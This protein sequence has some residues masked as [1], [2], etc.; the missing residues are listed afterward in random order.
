MVVAIDEAIAVIVSGGAVRAHSPQP[1]LNLERYSLDE[2]RRLR[3]MYSS[4]A[5]AEGQ[6]GNRTLV[7][8]VRQ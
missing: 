4:Q 1:G 7:R 5:A 6:G 3:E 8:F 2:L